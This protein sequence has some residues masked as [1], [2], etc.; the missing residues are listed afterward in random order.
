MSEKIPSWESLGQRLQML[1]KEEYESQKLHGRR[2]CS[3]ST[4]RLFGHKESEVRVT[5][6]RDHHAWCPYCQKI[7][8]WLEEQMVPYRVRKVTMFCYGEK[9]KWYNRLVPSGMLPALEMDGKLVT[10]SDI[11]LEHLQASF[12]C[13]NGISMH[14]DEVLQLRKL[15]RVLFSFWCR[16]LCYPCRTREEDEER[17]EQFERV[18]A[19]VDSALGST[20]GPYFLKV[21]SIVDIVFTPYVERMN[22]SLF[23]Y[24]GFKV[25]DPK[26]YPNVAAW[27]DAMETRESYLGTQ[28]D[29]HTHVHDLPPQM[30]GCYE[31]G[32]EEQLKAKQL[33]DFG[34]Y[35]L[36]EGELNFP[37]PPD[38]YLVAAA[39]MWV[40][41]A[42][43]C[44]VNPCTDKALVDESLRC[45]ITN[46]L[47]SKSNQGSVDELNSQVYVTPPKGGGAV[48]RY[49]RDRI[50]VPRDM[51]I[52]SARIARRILDCTALL[53]GLQPSPQAIP[54]QHRRDQDPRNFLS[55]S[56][57]K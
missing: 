21:F 23:Y 1:S 48:L 49:I 47:T 57:D 8:L 42:A 27:F 19:I 46:I 37:A 12:G 16:W 51:P 10:E 53:D 33:V 28:S 24:K 26:R 25:R 36:V 45:A 20:A 9:E 35:E 3:Q 6:Y 11:I 2:S 5:L 4:L 17:R 41:R 31:N 55:L 56:C 54:K 50:S 44:N 13:I 39:R 15:E 43:I 52:H 14:N 22:A 30:G 38:A 18:L 34:P 40:H 29:F 32:T 7:W